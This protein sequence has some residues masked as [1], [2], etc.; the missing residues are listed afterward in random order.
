MV[1][2]AD[3]LE[4][5][6][7]LQYALELRT[8]SVPRTQLALPFLQLDQLPPEEIVAELIERSLALPNVRSRQSRMAAPDS[9]A[10]WL[11]DPWAEGPR[12]AFIDNTEFCHLHPLPEFVI[13][14]T[15]PGSLRRLAV[16]L[17]WAEPHPV[18]R[19]GAVTPA[20]VL[21]Y[22]PRNVAELDPV[23]HLV[24]SSYEFARGL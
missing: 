5:Q 21:V 3:L 2:H 16:D 23:F 6:R 12:E 20:L 24:R 4:A 9:R 1:V 22:A 15:L 13:H 7:D 19:L 10:L 18:A 11:P 17:G 8:G 14:L